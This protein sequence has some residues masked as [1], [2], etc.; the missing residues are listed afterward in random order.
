MARSI[1][2]SFAAKRRMISSGGTG[3]GSGLLTGMGAGSAAGVVGLIG[4]AG[5]ASCACTQLNPARRSIVTP[6]E[7]IILMEWRF[8]ECVSTRNSIGCNPW[9]LCSAGFLTQSAICRAPR[10]C[11]RTTKAK[12]QRL[13]RLRKKSSRTAT[14]GCASMISAAKP[15]QA[16]VPVLLKAALNR[17]FP[18]PVKPHLFRGVYVVAEATTHKHSRIATL[19]L[20]QTFSRCHKDSPRSGPG[21]SA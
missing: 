16:R 15:A 6:R 12:L 5:P 21:R 13:N 1:S 8:I 19:T 2:S 18:Q 10:V 4:P 20:H 9:P 17:L 14:L 11:V 3:G 7:V